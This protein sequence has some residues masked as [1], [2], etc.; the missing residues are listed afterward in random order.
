M[1]LPLSEKFSA[2]LPVF[3]GYPKSD[4]IQSTADSSLLRSV[5]LISEYLQIC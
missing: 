5:L 2:R 4:A 3:T 1:I